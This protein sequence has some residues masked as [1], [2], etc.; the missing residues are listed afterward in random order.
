MMNIHFS[1]LVIQMGVRFMREFMIE[2]GHWIGMGV[3]F[4][5]GLLSF[6]F[7][8]KELPYEQAKEKIINIAV[9]LSKHID[10][11]RVFEDVASE[12]CEFMNKHGNEFREYLRS[13]N[14]V[15]IRNNINIDRLGDIAKLFDEYKFRYGRGKT[16]T[17]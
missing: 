11:S 13:K 1:D 17:G 5:L 12:F 16:I 15:S 14:L 7:T 6:F 4:I 3:M 2:Y 10:K 8:R 9:F